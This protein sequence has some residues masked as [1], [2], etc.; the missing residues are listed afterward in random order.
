M[1]SIA[2][3]KEDL[4]IPTL[5]LQRSTKNGEPTAWLRHWENDRRIAVSI[6]EDTLK[7]AKE[8]PDSEM[9]ILQHSDRISEASSQP[10][11]AYRIVKVNTEIE[12][13]L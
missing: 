9:F 7:Y 6:H 3:I 8:N 5:N 13:T 1:A 11:D 12:A 10:Y 4:H 2:Q